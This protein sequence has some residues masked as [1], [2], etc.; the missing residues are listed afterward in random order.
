MILKQ[1]TTDRI[2][3]LTTEMEM[4]LIRTIRE[5]FDAYDNKIVQ[6]E[7]ILLATYLEYYTEASE[8]INDM[9][10]GR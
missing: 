9:T 4:I 3:P 6:Q 10:S 1:A 8:M 2:I 5:A 7:K